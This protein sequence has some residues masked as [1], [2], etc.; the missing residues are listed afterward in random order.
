MCFSFLIIAF[1]PSTHETK[2][3]I[4][5]D[6]RVWIANYLQP[7]KEA[8]LTLPFRSDECFVTYR[9]RPLP[10]HEGRLKIVRSQAGSL[11]PHRPD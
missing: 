2:L 10:S 5:K 11:I 1:A 4:N 9:P 7:Y 3:A 8:R 6:Q